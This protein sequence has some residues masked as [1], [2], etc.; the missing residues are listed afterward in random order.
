MT[1]VRGEQLERLSG[2]FDKEA[3]PNEILFKENT[4]IGLK[5]NEV[6]D[7]NIRIYV[8]FFY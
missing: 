2:P 4:H 6:N 8:F 3:H 1:T 7:F 5:Q